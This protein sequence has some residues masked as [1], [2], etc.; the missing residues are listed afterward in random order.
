[1][2]QRDLI[3]IARVYQLCKLL[4]PFIEYLFKLRRR[5]ESRVFPDL[6][7]HNLT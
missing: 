6:R 1:M 7:R 4:L 2:G 3:A 5:L